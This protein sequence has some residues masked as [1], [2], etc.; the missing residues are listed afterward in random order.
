MTDAEHA[1]PLAA[2]ELPY[3]VDPDNPRIVHFADG[4]TWTYLE[5]IPP[6]ADAIPA[7][8]VVVHNH[9]RPARRLGTRGFRAWLQAPDDRVTVVTVCECGWAPEVGDHYRV[10]LEW[11]DP[12]PARHGGNRR[13]R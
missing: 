4:R 3:T 10:L 1:E 9:V 11:K 6:N 5:R 13:N 7:G 2:A 12:P 8:L